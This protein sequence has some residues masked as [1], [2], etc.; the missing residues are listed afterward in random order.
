MNLLPQLPEACRKDIMDPIIQKVSSFLI[1]ST[2]HLDACCICPPLFSSCAA[3]K[4]DMPKPC[5][6]ESQHVFFDVRPL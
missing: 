3:L 4:S 5:K 1:A 2:G 6:G